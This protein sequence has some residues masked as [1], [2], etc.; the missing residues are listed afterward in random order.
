MIAIKYWTLLIN[1]SLSMM[2]FFFI[3]EYTPDT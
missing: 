2:L 3:G 1:E